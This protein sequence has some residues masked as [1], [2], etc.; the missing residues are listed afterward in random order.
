MAGTIFVTTLTKMESWNALKTRPEPFHSPSKFLTTVT[1]CYL[2]VPDSGPERSS[3]L[4][5]WRGVAPR[6][7]LEGC[8]TPRRVRLHRATIGILPNVGG[9]QPGQPMTTVIEVAEGE[10]FLYGKKVP[11]FGG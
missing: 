6:R 5:C 10:Y 11:G 2:S 9:R 1:E 3:L 4:A 8:I 7:E